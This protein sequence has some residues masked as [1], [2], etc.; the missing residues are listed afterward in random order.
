MSGADLGYHHAALATLLFTDIEGSTR[1]LRR[2][3]DRYAT[4]LRDHRSILRE[5]IAAH[6]G[7]EQG[8]EGDSFF[9]LFE[10]AGDAVG[11]ALAAQLALRQHDWGEAAQVRVRM[12]T[13]SGDV[14]RADDGVVGL[15]VHVAARVSAAAHG[16]QVL[17]SEVTAIQAED[18][19]PPEASLVDLGRH[20][21]RDVPRPM[22]LFQLAH[23]SLDAS[24]PMPRTF[25]PAGG[26]LPPATTSFV[27]RGPERRAVSDLV[28]ANRMVTVTGPGG[29]GK[30]RLALEVARG[31]VAAS[32]DGCWFADLSGAG[33]EADVEAVLAGVFGA[34]PGLDRLLAVLRDEAPVI[35][36]DNCEQVAS[37]CAGVVARLLAAAP[38]VR[39]LATS[40]Q[41]LGVDGEV[42][43]PLRP[44]EAPAGAGM[45]SLDAVAG[46][47]SARLLV[48]RVRLHEPAFALTESD[49]G[50]LAALCAGLEGNALAIELAASRV[51]VLS[52]AECAERLADRFRLLSDA[53][54]GQGRHQTLYATVDWSYRLLSD[55]ERTFLDRLAVFAGGASLAAA[56]HVCVDPGASEW[57]ALDILGSLVAKSLVVAEPGRPVTRYREAETIREFCMSQLRERGEE[58]ATNRLHLAWVRELVDDL[59][60]RLE[61][62]DPGPALAAM[63]AEHA[64]IAAAI[65]WAHSTRDCDALVGIVAQ[66]R[67][68]MVQ[69]ASRGEH[70]S[71]V[72]WAL[73]CG[74]DGAARVDVLIEAILLALLLAADGEALEA[75]AAMRDEA[76]A[77]ARALGDRR[78][79]VRA[80]LVYHGEVLG[81]SHRSD[82]MLRALEALLPDVERYETPPFVASA[83][84]YTA[85]AL[86]RAGRTDEADGVLR[87]AQA[88]GDGAALQQPYVEYQ[89][90][91]V[92]LE[93]GDPQ[94][95]R[96]LFERSLARRA[97]T[98]VTASTS[99]ALSRLGALARE[100]GD[101]EGSQRLL[102]EA[103]G[104]ERRIGWPANLATI[105]AE[106]ACTRVAA[107]DLPGARA[108]ISEA[109]ASAEGYGAYS[110]STVELAR[111]D[112]ARA[113]RDRGAAAAHYRESIRLAGEYSFLAVSRTA[114]ARLDA[115]APD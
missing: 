30:T 24:F 100:E 32:P 13:H 29:S 51:G 65:E 83:L 42:I 108:D 110:M 36:L 69:G 93:R 43:Y 82:A 40:R 25:D 87:R 11:A 85:V 113:E 107:G 99:L 22:R 3:G 16:G 54:G 103:V 26:N 90:G 37:A 15:A 44:L 4:L 50:P 70:D 53:R 61:R 34:A 111:G 104:Q 27:G 95:A 5:A 60:P 52:L 67:E 73:E 109:A 68:Y 102:D 12:G 8:T 81:G 10:N 31:E 71:W 112:I 14:R 41:P 59:A 58:A 84:T 77:I 96:A 92:A 20:V 9:V 66:L 46:T 38:A 101:L 7:Q 94:R 75:P 76:V 78:R 45:H 114:Q 91:M 17:V 79:E 6:D 86:R 2:L 23:P 89:A 33:S 56:T 80:R 21:L 1:L 28:R 18:A 49:A 64:N 55:V 62:P 19:L 97:G 72:R 35:V 57:E 48:D 74:G 63:R 98:G 115:L 88:I 105:L 39:I 106:S 47:E